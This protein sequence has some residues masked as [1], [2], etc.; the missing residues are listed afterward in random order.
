MSDKMI[1]SGQNSRLNSVT[2][3]DFQPLP[4][5]M[6]DLPASSSTTRPASDAEPGL[7]DSV[8]VLPCFGTCMIIAPVSLQSP[9]RSRHARGRLLLTFLSLGVFLGPGPPELTNSAL[10]L[11]QLFASFHAFGIFTINPPPPIKNS[12]PE[13]DCA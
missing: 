5:I 11:E 1:A 10:S 9:S 3:T 12:R 2:W 7:Y 13:D 8:A 4:K 6:A